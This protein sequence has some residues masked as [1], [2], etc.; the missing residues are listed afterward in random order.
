MNRDKTAATRAPHIAIDLWRQM[1]ARARDNEWSTFDDGEP[2]AEEQREATWQA[3]RNAGW[4]NEEIAAH[5]E[6]D[7]MRLLDVPTTSPGVAKITE[8]GLERLRR[9]LSGALPGF[10]AAKVLVAHLQLLRS[11]RNARTSSIQTIDTR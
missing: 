10:D 4:S 2:G 11:D 8:V 3:F 1:L 5:F 6:L 7:R 9:A